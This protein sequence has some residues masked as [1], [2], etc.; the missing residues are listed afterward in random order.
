MGARDR[1]DIMFV[2]QQL[3][4]GRTWSQIAR[5]IPCSEHDLRTVCDGRYQAPDVAEAARRTPP[6]AS[7][8]ENRPRAYTTNPDRV[9]DTPPLSNAK[10]LPNTRPAAAQPAP[11]EET[12]MQKPYTP[13]PSALRPRMP[14]PDRAVYPSARAVAAAVVAAARVLTED[15]LTLRLPAG[16]SQRAVSRRF[17]FAAL[18]ALRIRY[19]G[20][21]AQS[22][23][24]LTDVPLTPSP[25]ANLNVA[26]SSK[27][28]PKFGAQALEAAL[29][30][31]DALDAKAAA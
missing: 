11:R 14:K 4:L 15:P 17:R 16:A 10:S 8:R 9:V 28:W 2:E 1:I 21:A 24:R 19:P 6:M 13:P 12:P 27:W 7:G 29:D 5:M 26:Q 23:A 22:L 31:I 20:V 18:A 3:A 25:V 30:A